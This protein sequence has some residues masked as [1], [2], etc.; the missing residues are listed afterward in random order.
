M[1]CMC[2]TAAE[3]CKITE[4]DWLKEYVYAGRK[5]MNWDVYDA[6]TLY[7]M[8]VNRTYYASIDPKSIPRRMDFGTYGIDFM[9]GTYSED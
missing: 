8:P 1:C 7:D 6:W 5:S 9:V 3:G 4:R 2:C